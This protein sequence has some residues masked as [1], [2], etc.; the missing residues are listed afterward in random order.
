M[1]KLPYLSEL[2]AAENVARARKHYN[3]DNQLLASKAGVTLS[4]LNHAIKYGFRAASGADTEEAQIARRSIGT[5]F[6]RG[7]PNKPYNRK[8]VDLFM[9]MGCEKCQYR[10]RSYRG[11]LKFS[12]EKHEINKGAFIHTNDHGAYALSENKFCPYANGSDQ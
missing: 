8:I 3:L 10:S 9:M 6:S 1:S 12:L 11:C 4:M 2:T 5:L 7:I